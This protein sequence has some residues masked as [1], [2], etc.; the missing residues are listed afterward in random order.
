MRTAPGRSGSSTPT[1][2]SP[3]VT[4]ATRG[5]RPARTWARAAEASRPISAAPMRIPR[6][7]TTDPAGMSLPAVRRS[8]PRSTATASSTK[9]SSRR[10]S[11]TRITASAPAGIAAPVEIAQASPGAELRLPAF[12]RAIRRRPAGGRR[13]GVRGAHRE[14]VHRGVVERRDVLWG[15]HGLGQHPPQRIA[16]RD[17]LGAERRGGLE[18]ASRAASNSISPAT[19]ANSS[20][21][22][23]LPHS[24]G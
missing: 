24:A 18:H 3:V 1:S 11:S 8:R 13:S 10:V 20:Q 14:A 5:R 17:L 23:L 21:C 4:T 7:S 12:R 9:P 16:Q 15:Q 6:S 19:T 2:S 22:S